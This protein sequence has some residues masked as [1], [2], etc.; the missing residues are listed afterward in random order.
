MA[1]KQTIPKFSDIYFAH[2]SAIWQGSVGVVCLYAT[3]YQVK[4]I[5]TF[6]LLVILQF[7]QGSDQGQ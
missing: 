6:I 3:W 4:T 2:A 1:A 7:G 5:A